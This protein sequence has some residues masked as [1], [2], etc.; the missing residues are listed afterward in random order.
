VAERA[1]SVRIDV[2]GGHT[3]NVT[4]RCK[5]LGGSAVNLDATSG[6]TGAAE[7][8]VSLPQISIEGIMST[9]KLYHMP[10]A[11][12]RVVLNALEE[13]GVSYE[14]VAIDILKGQQRAPSFIAINPKGKVPALVAEEQLLTENAAI[15]I[16]LDGRYPEAHLLPAS[17]S[18]IVKSQRQADLIWVSN[19]L[20]PL[21][22]AALLP[23]RMTTGEPAGVRAAALVQL[24][25]TADELER[26][27][28][29][30]AWWYGDQ[31]SIIDVYIYWCIATAKVA[32]L[33]LTK[34]PA[35]Q[36]YLGRVRARPSFERATKR[37]Q[38]ALEAAQIQLPPGAK[39]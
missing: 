10:G 29:R 24:E 25:L 17:D 4:Y 34:L 31:W 14:D 35:L 22:R 37:E 9:M 3:E 12:S 32:G 26:R 8:L 13:C 18:P 30:Q 19:T 1:H 28:T 36:G 11:C 2:T 21:V 27:F 39:L 6:D 38:V 16:Y 33:D 5:T 23:A 15:L 20:H 7:M